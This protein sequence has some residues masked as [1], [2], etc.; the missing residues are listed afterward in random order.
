[1]GNTNSTKNSKIHPFPNFSNFPPFLPLCVVPWLRFAAP[2]PSWLRQ[3][4]GPGVF[5]WQDTCGKGGWNFWKPGVSRAKLAS[6]TAHS[7]Q[8]NQCSSVFSLVSAWLDMLILVR[9]T[10]GSDP[11]FS[12]GEYVKE[13]PV[14]CNEPWPT[15]CGDLASVLE[16]GTRESVRI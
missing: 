13:D 5:N 9:Q 2:R 16:G 10:V 15:N 14:S 12:T 3:M 11:E 1:M 6:C 4:P 7:F 8:K